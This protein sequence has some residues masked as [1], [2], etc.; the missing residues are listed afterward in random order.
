MVFFQTTYDLSQLHSWDTNF[1]V[2]TNGF[3]PSM[4]VITRLVSFMQNGP[5]ETGV[6]FLVLALTNGG[7]SEEI[8]WRGFALSQLQRRLN[9]L[10]SSILVAMLWAA[11]HTGTLFWQTVLTSTLTDGLSFAAV[12]VIQYLILVTPL[13]ILYTVLYNG[14]HGSILLSI[15]LHAF[16]NISISIVSA[17][18]P[19]F[20]MIT[21]VILLWIIAICSTIVFWKSN[22]TQALGR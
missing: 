19:N 11:W 22:G 1:I 4:G 7:L 20:P 6:I 10:T 16:Y 2:R 13:S 12:Y 8:G 9:F 15:I 21:F 5:I 3:T 18:L 14:T 17:A